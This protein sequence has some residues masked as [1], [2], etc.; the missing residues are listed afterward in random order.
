MNT[1]PESGGRDQRPPFPLRDGIEF[2]ILAA[3]SL[4][5]IF[6]IIPAETTSGDELGLSP[7]LVPT[8]C[9][10]AIGILA[11]AHFLQKLIKR[12]PVE[13]SS[14]PSPLTA[15]CLIGSTIIGILMIRY[16]NWEV[17]GAILVILVSLSLHER[18]LLRLAGGAAF[19][20]LFLYIVNH[21]GI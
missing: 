13:Q 14:G 18:R 11:C 20:A 21:L 2:V 9:A 7:G 8:V 10:A 5:T 17:G 4:I 6:V 15:I 19:V 12:T 1:V 16:I 3:L